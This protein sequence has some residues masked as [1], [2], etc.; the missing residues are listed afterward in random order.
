[1][2]KQQYLHHLKSLLKSLPEPER[3]EIISD[4]EE[5][6]QIGLAKG[7][8][9]ADISRSLGDVKSIAKQYT[10][11]YHVTKAEK[12]S[13]AVNI[14]QAV[15]AS[16]GLGFFNLVFVL[17]P[18]MAAL[19]VLIT[20]FGISISFALGGFV[21]MIAILLAPLLP[22]TIQIA[23]SLPIGFFSCLGL[24]AVGMLFFIGNLYL[25]RYFFKVTVV[26]LKWNMNIIIR[27][28]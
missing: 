12:E 17:G 26:Y 2:N 18:F 13:T 16:L 7:K 21:G 28:S 19:S 11:D 24:T 20:L 5:H 10:A 3:Q 27:R 4:Y 9:E 22:G 8:S 15:L 25:T 6:F 1:M 14:L 23:I